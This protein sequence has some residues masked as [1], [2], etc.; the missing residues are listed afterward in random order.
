[1]GEC[2]VMRN[3]NG[4]LL[5]EL[6]VACALSLL[7]IA[8]ASTL[9]VKSTSWLYDL[10]YGCV[11]EMHVAN[12]LERIRHCVKTVQRDR[13]YLVRH[14]PHHLEWM[15]V[16]ERCALTYDADKKRLRS[17]HSVR[18]GNAE[19][20][21]RGCT[22]IL[23]PVDRCHLGVNATGGWIRGIEVRLWYASKEYMVYAAV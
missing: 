9:M 11:R 19:V 15:T 17:C 23:F 4:F 8:S 21:K 16:T 6:L 18:G 7:L 5:I 12:S 13:K 2:L 1:M 3:D 14:E 22:T 10:S 20:S